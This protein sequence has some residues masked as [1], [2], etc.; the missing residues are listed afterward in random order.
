MLKTLDDLAGHIVVHSGSVSDVDVNLCA[1]V[2][3]EMFNMP[4]FFD[5]YRSLGVRQF[6]VLD[7]HSG[8][9]TREFLC[10][11]PDCVVLTSRL[12]FGDMVDAVYPDGKKVRR[13]WG[14]VAKSIIPRTYLHDKYALYVDADEFLILPERVGDLTTAFAILAA[15]DIDAV[16]AHLVE[17]YPKAAVDLEREVSPKTFAEMIDLYP[18]FDARPLIEVPRGEYPRNLRRSASN[19]LFR[20]NRTW[21]S[22]LQ[23]RLRPKKKRMKN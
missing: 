10:E 9:G 20:Q 11:Q 1:I 23:R 5:H 12:R 2:R 4:A 17:F 16:A 22:R 6:L 15:H 18:Y 14:T 7:Y 3:D 13:R 21:F 8:D 19:R